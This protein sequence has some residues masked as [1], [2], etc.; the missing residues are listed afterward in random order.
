MWVV[1]DASGSRQASNHELAMRRLQSNGAHIV[2]FEM[3]AFEWLQTC[4]H[5]RFKPVLQVLK[6]G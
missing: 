5:P 1:A 3:V 4:E 2:S 6:G